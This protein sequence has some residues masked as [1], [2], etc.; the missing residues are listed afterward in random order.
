VHRDNGRNPNVL[1]I[2]SEGDFWTGLA[3][4]EPWMPSFGHRAMGTIL[5]ELFKRRNKLEAQRNTLDRQLDNLSQMIDWLGFVLH[6]PEEVIHQDSASEHREQRQQRRDAVQNSELPHRHQILEPPG[7]LRNTSPVIDPLRDMA[8]GAYVQEGSA[9]D[10]E[11]WQLE[12]W[13]VVGTSRGN[14]RRD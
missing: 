7:P 1:Q 5:S 2:V 3:E 9:A 11:I 4:L 6:Q 13:L 10:P 8:S 12:D 14:A